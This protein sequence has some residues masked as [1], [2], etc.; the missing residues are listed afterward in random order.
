MRRVKIWI[1]I[2]L[3]FASLR[4]AAGNGVERDLIDYGSWKHIS[5]EVKK[6]LEAEVTRSCPSVSVSL[7][8]GGGPLFEIRGLR[9][10]MPDEDRGTNVIYEFTI[11]GRGLSGTEDAVRMRILQSTPDPF[12]EEARF[13]WSERPLRCD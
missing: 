7:T 11:R 4:L 2:L 12:L 1:H 13:L 5:P 6:A 10:V 3:M 8:L 9:V